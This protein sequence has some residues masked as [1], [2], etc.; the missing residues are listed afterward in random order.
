MRTKPLINLTYTEGEGG[1]M[2]PNIQMSEN[3]A[4]DSMEVG[5]YGRMWKD[6]MTE[7]HPHRVSQLIAEGKI[8]QMIVSVDK[9]AD[10]RKETLIQQL[11]KVQPM[12]QTED[13]LMRASHME[14]IYQ[15][16]EE[17]ILNEIVYKT[18]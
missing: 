2:Y 14:M 17:I 12:P 8:N 18:R 10:S 16:A 1:L 9:E 7:Q 13:T 4:C 6:Y 5:K 11:L 15:T 3:P